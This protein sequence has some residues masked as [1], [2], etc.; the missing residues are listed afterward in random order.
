MPGV[1]YLKN[2]D[3]HQV[4]LDKT[5]QMLH[6][7]ND[8]GVGP[9]ASVTPPTQPASMTDVISTA[10]R[11]VGA[12]LSALADSESFMRRVTDLD[13]SDTAGITAAVAD[14]VAYN[15]KL[16]ADTTTGMR[17]NPAQGQSGNPVPPRSQTLA[18]KIR[19]G[20]G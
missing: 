13:P 16:G 15:P 3:D 8:E 9:D 10:A 12:D 4:W 17:P 14:A 7:S 5:A 2:S 20:H 11:A 18:E 1:T 6:P 19:A